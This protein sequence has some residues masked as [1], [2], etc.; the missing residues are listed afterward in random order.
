M[1]PAP[2][3]AVERPTR[4]RWLI[5]ALCCI[6]SW[7]LYVH[8]YCCLGVLKP[9]LK[10]EY[11]DLSAKQLG[12]LD[13]A[14]MAT[15]SL[16]QIPM[17][18][19][20]DVLGPRLVLSV[21]ILAWSLTL[22][23]LALAPD[24][25]TLVACMAAFGLSQA[26]AY[27][28]LGTVTRSWFPLSIR[29]TVQGAV[30]TLSGRGG[31]ACAPLIVATLLIAQ[32]GL[33]WRTAFLL[34]AGLGCAFA[35]VF[36][37]LFRNSPR[38]HPWANEAEARE[39]SAGE[40]PPAPGTRPA[41]SR[42]PRDLLNFSAVLLLAFAGTFG[43]AIYGSWI[44]LFL[45]EAKGLRMDEMGV[46]SSLPLLG[47]AVGG[48][49]G[50][51]LNDVLMRATGSRRLARSAVGS[52]GKL[53]AGVLITLSVL[54][55][56]GRLAMLVLLACKFFADWSQPTLWGTMTDI[57]GRAAGTVFGLVNMVGNFGAILAGLAMGHI[58]QE[59]GWDTLFFTVAVL[60]LVCAVLWLF[61]DCTRRLVVETEAHSS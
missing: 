27:P 16:G 49:C 17:G 59:H 57:S 50:G 1:G 35:L 46:F 18:T 9:A 7:L 55:A 40:V 37:L 28:N 43:D 53:L 42:N 15:Y 14:F 44:P 22:G 36:G 13:S 52:A 31:G 2:S 23:G 45:V 5:F 41:L 30:A 29:T 32:L 12:A 10:Q 54:V 19:A 39:V 56:D 25:L 20:G 3:S 51:L 34:L 33:D 11:P 48:F 26:G 21:I 58:I 47:G 8:R 24:Y 61:I 38:E 60:Y 6:T 4:V